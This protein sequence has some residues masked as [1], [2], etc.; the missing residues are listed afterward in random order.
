MFAVGRSCPRRN[1]RTGRGGGSQESVFEQHTDRHLQSAREDF[2][3]VERRIR[4]AA[5]YPA[6]VGPGQPTAVSECFLRHACCP[7]KGSNT[8]AEFLSERGSHAHESESAYTTSPRTNRDIPVP[9][10]TKTKKI[11]LD[12]EDHPYG[13]V[14]RWENL[15]NGD[16]HTLALERPDDD[17]VSVVTELQLQH[18]YPRITWRI[19]WGGIDFDDGSGRTWRVICVPEDEWATAERVLDDWLGFQRVCNPFD[20]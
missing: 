14:L 18:R 10:R 17:I 11:S 19:T 7:P 8:F 5:F 13:G 6:H 20:L 2:Y 9:E 12:I 3:R 1:C 4:L 16:E 15:S